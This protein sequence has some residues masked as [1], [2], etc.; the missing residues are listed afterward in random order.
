ML[1]LLYEACPSLV[2]HQPDLEVRRYTGEDYGTQ[3]HAFLLMSDCDKG[4]QPALAEVF[5]NNFAM[6]CAMHIKSNVVQRFGQASARQ[7][8]TIAKTY[9]AR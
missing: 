5:P 3:N 4:L 9:S 2:V 1:H 7:I 8:I 6:S